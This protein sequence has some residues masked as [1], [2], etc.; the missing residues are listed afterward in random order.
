MGRR[1]GSTKYNSNGA[2]QSRVGYG[3]QKTM[4]GTTTPFKQELFPWDEL[5]RAKLACEG[6]PEFLSY[7]GG[8]RS[9]LLPCKRARN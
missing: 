3:S 7:L 1:T 2:S 6:C 4:P 5:R 9:K 8:C